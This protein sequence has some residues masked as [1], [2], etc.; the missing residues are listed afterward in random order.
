MV[1]LLLGNYIYLWPVIKYI[2]VCKCVCVRA[3]VCVCVCVCDF[4]ITQ[5]LQKLMIP[6]ILNLKV[7]N[8][9]W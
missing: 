6:Y 2:V 7:D 5:F 1:Q 9:L 4:L 3:C 8:F